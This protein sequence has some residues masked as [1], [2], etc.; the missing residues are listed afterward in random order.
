MKNRIVK[1]AFLNFFS[2]GVKLA[3]FAIITA[4]ALMIG[5]ASHAADKNTVAPV[6]PPS[7]NKEG[8]RNFYEVLDDLLGD[9][10]YDLKNGNVYGLKDVAIRNIATSENIPPSFRNHLE[11]LIT[12]RILKNSKSRIIQCLPC[13]SKRTT[14]NGDQVVIT[15]PDTNPLELS[16]IAKM[17]GIAHFFDA[18]F[19]YQPSGMVLSM[20]IAEPESGSIIWSRSYNSETSRASAFRR[21]VDYSQLDDAR[22]ATEY[23]PTIQYRIGIGYMYEPNILART[24]CLS[25]GFRAMERYD[26]R[27]KEVGFSAEYLKDASTIV[28]TPTAAAASTAT[29]NLYSGINLTLLFVH[30]WSLIGDEENYN[31]VRGSVSFGVGGTYASGFLGGLFRG[32]YE[33]RLGKHYS[34]NTNLG[35]RPASTAVLSTSTTQ[36]VSGLEYGL[37]VNMLF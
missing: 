15:S 33:W 10:E 20:F 13:R 21:G 9:F 35:Y 37:A 11:L 8:E 28:G 32:S 18:S 2:D 31:K 30:G 5:L 24:G 27:K 1:N 17:S 6:S 26:N 12:E 34:V 16:R 4:P 29:T 36:A 3:A 19:S 25:L 23:A 22:R 7:V 14:L